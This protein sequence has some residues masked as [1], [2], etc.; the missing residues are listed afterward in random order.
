LKFTISNLSSILSSYTIKLDFPSSF[1]PTG[2]AVN[3]GKIVSTSTVGNYNY[4]TSVAG[5]NDATCTADGDSVTIADFVT[6]TVKANSDITFNLKNINVG[7][8]NRKGADVTVSIMSGST[9]I[10][11]C[12]ASFLG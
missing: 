9:V 3:M 1:D 7:K 5:N 11:T 10:S 8:K 2:C 4:K 12:T 6:T